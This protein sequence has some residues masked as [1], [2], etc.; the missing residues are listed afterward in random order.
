MQLLSV[1]NNPSQA[2]QHAQ[3]QQVGHALLA[4]AA[5]NV[6]ERRG[7]DGGGGE[8]RV[9][10]LRDAFVVVCGCLVVCGGGGVT[11]VVV[12]VVVVVRLY[13]D[14]S[15]SWSYLRPVFMC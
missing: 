10:S 15:S 14:D 13:L 12:V 1:L 6:S 9:S 2:E 8:C 7:V 11:V 3:A 4:F 5:R